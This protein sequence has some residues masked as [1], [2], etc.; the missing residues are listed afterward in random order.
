M[1]RTQRAHAVVAEKERHRRCRHA[2]GMTVLEVLVSVVILTMASTMF[3]RILTIGDRVQ[4]RTIHLDRAVVLATGEAERLK[5]HAA[6]GIAA[7]DTAYEVA[8]GTSVLV[9]ERGPVN[10]TF[11]DALEKSVEER[12]IYIRVRKRES[13]SALVSFRL[14]QPIAQALE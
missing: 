5:A 3:L 14:L 12:E 4:T 9:V 7:G 2:R 13:D 8:F 10:D 6:E 11:F 1:N